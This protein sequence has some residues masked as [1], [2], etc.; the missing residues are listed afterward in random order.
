MTGRG[1]AVT[2][3]HPGLSWRGLAAA[4]V[5]PGVATGI[6]LVA[7]LEGKPGPSGLFVGAVGVAAYV[8]GLWAGIIAAGLSFLA[9]EYFFLDPPWSAQS[10]LA[11]VLFVLAA[12]LVAQVVERLHVARRDAEGAVRA[13]ETSEERAR[14]LAREQE[15]V[16][17]LGRNALM[18]A[19]IVQ[20]MDEALVAVQEI[21][22]V[23]C[24]EVLEA[25]RDRSEL[26]VA[27]GIGL[28]EDVGVTPIPVLDS[29]PEGRALLSNEPV[30][31]DGAEPSELDPPVYLHDT[32][33]VSHLVVPVRGAVRPWGLFAAHSSTAGAFAE[34]DVYF[35]RAV[36][37]VLGAA[38]LRGETD[39]ALRETRDELEA[40]IEASP[41][42]I[43]AYDQDG[44]VTLWNAAAQTVFG[45]SAEEAIGK[46]LP[47]VQPEKLDEFEIVRERVLAGES[48]S[49]FET[50][51][52]RKD[53]SLLEVAFWNAPIRDA[54]G[55]FRGVVAV[56]EDITERKRIERA[57]RES[58]ERLRL[59]LDAGEMG[60]WEWDLATGAITWSA[61]L[62]PIHGL[63]PGTFD[64]TF[65]QYQ[66]LIN[67]EDRPLVL[68]A[69]EAALEEPE[70]GY[71]VEFRVV[72]PDGT[73]RWISG[74]AQVVRGGDG[75]PL[76]MVGLARDITDRKRHERAL[77][78][79]AEASETLSSSL[80]YAR[81]LR[82]VARLAVPRLADCCLVDVL[83]GD[84]TMH[85]LA[86]IHVDPAKEMLVE[87]LEDRY[88]AD[89]HTERSVV[90]KVLRSGKPLL[91]SHVDDG[92]AQEIAQDEQHLE[93]LRRLR[94][95]S[96]LVAPL[97][98]RGQT[99][100]AMT[101]LSGGS[102]RHFGPEDVSLATDLA[103]HA[104][105]AIDN[106]RQHHL[107]SD[108]AATLQR[109]LLP[110]ALPDIPGIELAARYFPA[111]EGLEVGGDFYD[112]FQTG[113]NTW[114]LVIGDVCGKGPQAAA[115]TGLTRHTLRGAAV[116]E[117]LPSGS[118]RVLNDALLA[119]QEHRTFC[120]VV[121][122]R[123]R[124]TP[125]A[126][127]LV[128]ACGGH[129]L[130]I[131][132]PADG[133]LAEVGSWGS[134]VGFF[135]EPDFTDEMVSLSPGDVVFFYTDGLVEGRGDQMAGGE[136]RL[137]EVL[138]KVAG[139]S[140]EEIAER[141]ERAVREEERA[142]VQDDTAFLVLRRSG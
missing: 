32:D 45:W 72:W 86:V 129:P 91:V 119:L 67:P 60:T 71:D 140:A 115:V 126:V 29:T 125:D 127:D 139:A 87:E 57:L 38:I 4:V 64:G 24:V 101:L 95:D 97:V 30:V 118:L 44:L 65:E 83:E 66:T 116:R 12:A 33:V 59:A 51:R 113:E 81:T 114:S 73:E 22:G 15:A 62:E 49:G 39:E 7:G 36:A 79:L 14:A 82:E 112:A 120:T 3:P 131:L 100:G 99:T 69:V 74:Q 56:V 135:E 137:R 40:L 141:V 94:I 34:P 103:R 128:L 85:Q 89:P 11:G 84:G 18:G 111:G 53:G 61:S 1:R 70:S 133:E 17:R 19:G 80:D 55:Q 27:R 106:A 132:I 58:E 35:V 109:S 28:A 6:G 110:P 102:G 48:F 92:M 117:R 20:L 68:G 37:N 136:Q 5:L 88:P 96:I 142:P 75:K 8:G 76:R 41:I 25:S 47:F 16:A 130:P 46:L 21:L 26:V 10:I 63:E 123:L 78:F 138:G 31:V 122:A 9:Y 90:G 98:V 121:K 105:M 13:L 54:A 77:A 23:A 107:R 134:L 108:I 124:V 42:P 43:V 52:R 93:G 2:L 50:V 104:A